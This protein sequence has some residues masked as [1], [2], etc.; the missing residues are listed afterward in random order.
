MASPGE[1]RPHNEG[2]PD[3]YPEIQETTKF[4]N[5]K[6]LLE[7]CISLENGEEL[8]PGSPLYAYQEYINNDTN[9]QA[10]AAAI[11]QVWNNPENAELIHLVFYYLHTSDRSTDDVFAELI[12][13][14]AA[15]LPPGLS[16]DILRDPHTAEELA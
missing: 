11:S 4:E 16:I 15:H 12:G 13:L 5:F 8:S 1:A 3:F 10:T 9:G 2:D 14:T 6:A 7:V